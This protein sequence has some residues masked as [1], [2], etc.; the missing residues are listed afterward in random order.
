[1][2]RLN[3][4]GYLLLIVVFIVGCEEDTFIH[5][6]VPITQSQSLID[7]N[8]KATITPEQIIALGKKNKSANIGYESAAI[9]DIIVLD[10]EGLGNFDNINNFYNGGTS[11]QGFSG[12]NYGVEFGVALALIDSDEGG[13]GSIAN[14]PSPSTVMFFLDANQAFMNVAAGFDTGLS[15]FYS[16]NT[17][18]AAVSVYDGLNGTGNLLGSINLARNFNINCTGD[19]TGAYCNW[20]P[21][22][23]PFEGTA[24]SVVFSGAANFVAFDDVTF[25]S[26]T[27]GVIDSD[28]DGIL[29]ENDNCPNTANPG[30]EDNDGDGRGDAC[31]DDDDNDGILDV[32]DNCPFTANP[33]QEDYDGDGIGD[34]CDDDIDG[35]GCLNIND[36]IIR[37]DIGATIEIDGCDNGVTNY[38]TDKCGYTMN[39]M[40]NILEE[41]EYINH[42][43]FV[44]AMAKLV[45]EWYE[46]GLVTVEEK[47]LIMSCAGS[48]DIG[49]K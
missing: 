43:A 26:T 34:V 24:K 5:N 15:F 19:P 46:K 38:I 9:R 17:G 31:D 25:G 16:S 32:N 48:S 13:G 33:G 29:D 21:I 42:G 6:E 28:G 36:D 14:E 8:A 3:L 39:D 7:P 27:P 1:M 2:K 12:T 40:I 35:D 44:S 41:A 20:D 30:Q 45:N 22:A 11:S 4:Y 47:D 10:F 37:S 18:V 23:V 49:R